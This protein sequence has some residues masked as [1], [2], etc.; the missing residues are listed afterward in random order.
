M[1]SVT[2]PTLTGEWLCTR[3]WGTRTM[4]VS[5]LRGGT[6]QELD[7]K[8]REEEHLYQRTHW[9]HM[10]ST[11]VVKMSIQ[12]WIT[13]RI[14]CPNILTYIPIAVVD[15]YVQLAGSPNTSNKDY[16]YCGSCSCFCLWLAWCTVHVRLSQFARMQ[17]RMYACKY[18]LP[19]SRWG[20]L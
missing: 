14:T 2:T 18:C 16:L 3:N 15:L 19:K 9:I 8:G 20:E 1:L 12:C 11:V 17:V 10:Y 7:L 5:Q 6:Y 4:S 13:V